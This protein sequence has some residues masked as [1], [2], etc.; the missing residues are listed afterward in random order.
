MYLYTAQF[1]GRSWMT[2]CAAPSL[3]NL[4]GQGARVEEYVIAY[5]ETGIPAARKLVPKRLMWHHGLWRTKAMTELRAV[6][7]ARVLGVST[8]Q[9]LGCCRYPSAIES[10]G[11][12]CA[13][14]DSSGVRFRVCV[15]ADVDP[16]KK[17]YINQDSDAS[18]GP[19]SMSGGSSMPGR[20]GRHLCH[21]PVL[22][23]A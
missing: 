7:S 10:D 11:S 20:H 13:R 12:G 14:L 2:R 16:C 21:F 1:G 22:A 15:F 23:G 18:E 5:L 19:G 6:R 9:Q 3:P 4:S 17:P 8:L